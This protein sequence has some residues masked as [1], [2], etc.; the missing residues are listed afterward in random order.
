MFLVD[1]PRARMTP[2]SLRHCLTIWNKNR[3]VTIK[4]TTKNTAG[5][6]SVIKL[7]ATSAS[8]YKVMASESLYVVAYAILLRNF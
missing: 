3:A 5:A 1:S 8:L 4:T 6:N 2:I 7:I